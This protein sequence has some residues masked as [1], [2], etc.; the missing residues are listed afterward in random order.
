MAAMLEID[1]GHRKELDL[2]VNKI[3]DNGVKD[4]FDRTRESSLL[5]VTRIWK[6]WNYMP[7]I[8]YLCFQLMITTHNPFK[9]LCT[10]YT[11][12]NWSTRFTSRAIHTNLL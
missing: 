6:N 1:K 10:L 9:E 5:E 8:E 3:T 12:F 2:S 7:I 11:L 4:L